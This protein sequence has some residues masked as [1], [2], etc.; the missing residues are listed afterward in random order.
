MKNIMGFD[1]S[2]KY[3]P[4]N[5]D[6]F[7]NKNLFGTATYDILIDIDM[8]KYDEYFI[9]TEFLRFFIGDGVDCPIFEDM[10][11]EAIF[12]MIY[13]RKDR[14]ILSLCDIT[15]PDL[16]EGKN[17]LWRSFRDSCKDRIF[18]Y[19]RTS[20]YDALLNSSILQDVGN[21]YI[22]DD[23]SD[24]VAR[25]VIEGELLENV[26]FRRDKINFIWVD[27]KS[28]ICKV[29]ND[30]KEK[31]RNVRTFFV[32]DVKGLKKLIM[33]S[34]DSRFAGHSFV[35]PNRG[36][37]VYTDGVLGANRIDRIIEDFDL[38]AIEKFIDIKTVS[39]LDI[40]MSELAVG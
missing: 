34:E 18:R 16:L 26:H 22:L 27:D 32:D 10:D 4:L 35:I 6:A 11:D 14:D 2:K 38:L 40:S 8:L 39:L 25:K 15:S 17:E 23:E 20:I 29:F 28:D 21:I 3:V 9:F 30:N 36:W 1:E 5:I 13:F 12:A 24:E 19:I 37:N 33:T 31:L 7:D